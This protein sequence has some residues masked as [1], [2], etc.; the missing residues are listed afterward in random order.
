MPDAGSCMSYSTPVSSALTAASTTFGAPGISVRTRDIVPN[1][2]RD[3]S[4]VKR[5]IFEQ[6]FSSTGTTAL[7]YSLL[8]RSSVVDTRVVESVSQTLPC[9]LKSLFPCVSD[10]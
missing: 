1:A 3:T 8:V 9:C 5:F 10:V 6:E 7:H 2:E 4:S